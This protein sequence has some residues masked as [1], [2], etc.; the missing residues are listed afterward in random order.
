MGQLVDGKWVDQWYDTGKSGGA[1]QRTT[2]S[3]RGAVGPGTPHPAEAGRYQ[4]YVSLACPWAHRTL[5]FRALKQLE[6]AISVSIVEP[7][8]LE[9]GWTSA[10]SRF[11]RAGC[12]AGSAR[13]AAWSRQVDAATGD[14]LRIGSTPCAFARSPM[15]AII[16]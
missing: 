10:A 4:L 13:L 14:T 1:F 16:A 9:Q 7:L 12:F 3:F 8:M 11:A 6:H 15:N 2:T 5:I